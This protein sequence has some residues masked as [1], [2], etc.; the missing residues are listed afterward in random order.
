MNRPA[1]LVAFDLDGVLYSS[2]PFLGAAYR[3]AIANVN[4]ARP[5]SFA[6]IPSTREILDHVGW[7]IPVIFANLFPDADEQ[8]LA[9]LHTETLS[10]I[11]AYIVRGDGVLYPDVAETLQ[12]L[13]DRG[14]TLAVASNGRTDYV[15]TVL[16]TYGLSDLFIPRVTAD[17]VGDK[18]SILRFYVYRLALDRNA[19]VMVGDRASDVDAARAVGCPS[20]AATTA[21]ATGTRSR[22]PGRWW[23]ALP[24]TGNDSKTLSPQ[25]HE[26]QRSLNDFVSVS[27]RLRGEILLGLLTFQLRRRSRHIEPQK[28][29]VGREEQSDHDQLRCQRADQH[30]RGADAADE[31]AD[32]EEAE[33]R[34]VEQRA[35]DVHRFDQVVDEHREGGEADR[36][37]PQ[38][39]V[40][41]FDTSRS[42][43]S[44]VVPRC[45]SRL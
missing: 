22:P 42:C 28:A 8:A 40:N 11:C 19:V 24:T 4:A 25:R 5:G 7:P 9:A 23:H 30:R 45:H 41:S 1:A 27:P 17:M 38:S 44:E 37:A 29:E 14:F 20:S 21:T 3:E 35:E 39:T 31:E 36:N 10:V 13:R 16:S 32:D 33:Q 12:T 2:E 15:E 43:R 34:P 6:R 18:I 26:A